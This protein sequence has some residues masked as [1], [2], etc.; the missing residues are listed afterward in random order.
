M[1]S[2]HFFN[3]GDNHSPIVNDLLK[4]F[5]AQIHE[6]LDENGELMNSNMDDTA[7]SVARKLDEFHHKLTRQHPN[8]N[9]IRFRLLLPQGYK[10]SA[11]CFQT[12]MGS[13]RKRGITPELLLANGQIKSDLVGGSKVWA[14]RAAI[15][16]VFSVNPPVESSTLFEADNEKLES[17]RM[18]S[19]MHK[20][21]CK[22]RELDL[23]DGDGEIFM[24]VYFVQCACKSNKYSIQHRSW[25]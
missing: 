18:L 17:D 20:V 6:R 4:K 13:S 25:C 22:V 14:T 12:K 3:T 11:D 19:R 10:G 16:L 5:N 15:G 23:N 8:G 24:F 21:S 2:V 7:Y 1:A 9:I